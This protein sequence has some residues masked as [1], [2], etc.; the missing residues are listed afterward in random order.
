MKQ[1]YDYKAVEEKWQ[2]KWK[3]KKLYKSEDLLKG[4]K[5][6]VLVEF[7]YPSGSGL[8]V[9][10]AFTM[11]GADVYARYRRVVGD[12][13]M[14]PMGWDA[15]GLP[16]ENYAIK[17]KIKP[18][19]ATEQNVAQFKRQMNE[20]AFSFD[21]DREI[22]TTDPAYYRW[23]QW[24]FLQL[25]DKGLAYKQKQPINW[26]PSCKIGLANEEVVDGN[27]ERCGAGVSR[28]EISQW[29][30]KI[31][32]YADQL[33]DELDE[34]DFP[35]HVAA[36][37][38][39]WIGRTEGVTIN[40]PLVGEENKYVSCY[41]TRPDTN[42]GATFVVIAPENELSIE[43]A[44][45]DHRAAVESY[46][47]ESKKKSERE[48][49][50]DYSART[51]VFTG[52]YC[53]N[54]LTGKEMPIW[55]ADFVI[56]SAGTGV[57]VGVPAHDERDF[58]FAKQNDIEIIPVIQPETDWNFEKSP[59]HEIDKGEMINSDFLN[60]M[61]PRDAKD[62]IIDYLVEKGWG[63]RAKNYHLRDW[64]FSRQHYW[65]EPIPMINCPE[66]GWVPVPEGEL[67]IVLPDVEQYE[68]T[69]TGDSPLANIRDW[70]ETTCPKCG[71]KAERE[72]DTMPNW[73]GSSWYYL[74]YIDPHNKD[75]IG[76]KEKLDYWQPVDIYVGGSEHTTLHLLYSRFWHKVL[77]DIGVAPGREPYIKRV[78]HGVILGPDGKRMS[79]SKGNVIVPDDVSKKHGVDVVRAY[80][81]F[82][83]PF[84]GTMPWNESTLMGVKRFLNRFYDFV[85]KSLDNVSDEDSDGLK[86]AL[87]KTIKKVGEGID[88][89]HFNTSIAASMELLNAVEKESSVTLSTLRIMT[90]LIAP[91]APYISEELWEVLGGTSSIHLEKWPMVDESLLEEGFVTI[92]VQ[93]N[94]K[95]RGDIQVKADEEE[96]SVREKAFAEQNVKKFVE[97]KNVVKFIYVPGRIVNV[98][99]R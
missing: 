73:A 22:N 31:T 92:G 98:V 99:V 40:Y 79:K 6:Y 96:S 24:I 39:N 77:N 4:N 89:F 29:V 38:K 81:M 3:D 58:D 83:G 94:G 27:C 49:I 63:D 53:R 72:T 87:N 59:Y 55:V 97:G 75:S 12:N 32:E 18:Q 30:L 64:I 78:E 69:D 19:D 44:D 33:I 54:R 28:R 62:K 46:I 84:D 36:R 93:V 82:M 35:E 70:V 57:V 25:Y 95:V 50:S 45:E 60:G 52:R 85:N 91:F 13:V 5:K 86:T 48:R 42:F 66:C 47:E 65:G 67:P 74:R 9:G 20:L 11:T 21:W 88:S 68:P 41:S 90:Q 16:T 10:H 71:G 8:H 26:C 7:P 51:G 2:K 1:K 76:S 80:L 14:F 37:Q 34:T 61:K 17:N 56:A 15:F 23:T 43:I